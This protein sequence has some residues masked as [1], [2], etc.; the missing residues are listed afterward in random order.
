MRWFAVKFDTRIH[1]PLR[2]DCNNVCNPLISS[3]DHQFLQYNYD[4]NNMTIE[5]SSVKFSILLV[6][7]IWFNYCADRFNNVQNQSSRD[8]KKHLSSTKHSAI[9]QLNT[10][11][12]IIGNT[13]IY[14]ISCHNGYCEKGQHCFLLV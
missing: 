13:C 11:I 10:I 7:N 5:L 6:I 14:P 9:M 2:M 3:G 4:N 12:N 8:L 1:V